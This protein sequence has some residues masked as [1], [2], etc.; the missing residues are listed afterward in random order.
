M[1]AMI[2]LAPDDK[3]PCES[4][5]VLRRCCL[6]AGGVLRPVAAVTCPAEPKTGIRND[7][8]YAAALADCSID[9]SRKHISARRCSSS[10]PHRGATIVYETTE[11]GSQL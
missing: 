8:C 11:I 4:G 9:V 6:S 3:C 2:R 5:R 7:G 10:L 1:E